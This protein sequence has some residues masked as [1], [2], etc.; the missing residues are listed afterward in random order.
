MIGLCLDTS[1]KMMT[2]ALWEGAEVLASHSEP[3]LQR[4]SDLMAQVMDSL[5]RGRGLAVKDIGIVAVANGPGSFTGLRVGISYAKGL[6]LGLGCRIIGMNT[7]EALALS[8][9]I[10]RGLASPMLDAKRKQVYAALYALSGP[11]LRTEAEP[12]AVE[13]GPWLE[14]L[15]EGTAVLG[16]GA[17]EYRSLMAA[18]QPR[19]RVLAGP[20]EP[21]PEGLVRLAL[22]RLEGQASADVDELD[23]FYLRKADAELKE[24]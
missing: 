17:A 21:T 10:D 13:P 2:M 6:A 7:L 5:L 4:H 24:H 19:L 8:S 18:H 9:G 16:S 3:A 11:A 15:P 14:K 20:E 1:G 23:A 22:A 12:V